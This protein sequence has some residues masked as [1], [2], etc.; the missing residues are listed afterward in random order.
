MNLIHRGNAISLVKQVHGL[1][2][3]GK[4]KRMSIVYCIIYPIYFSNVYHEYDIPYILMICV[5]D[6][7]YMGYFINMIEIYLRY[8]CEL[9]MICLSC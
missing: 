7:F 3:V 6:M 8:S 9:P 2:F 4:H 5:S 1:Y